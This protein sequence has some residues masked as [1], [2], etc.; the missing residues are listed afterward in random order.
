VGPKIEAARDFVIETSGSAGIGS[1]GDALDII[2]GHR[3]TLV[4]CRPGFAGR[5]QDRP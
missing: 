5:S 2:E 1:L 4:F 3:G